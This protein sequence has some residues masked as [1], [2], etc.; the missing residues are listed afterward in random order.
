M[1]CL[2]FKSL[3][4]LTVYKKC[5]THARTRYIDITHV[6]QHHGSELCSS[7][8]GLHALTGC[9][10]VSAFSGFPHLVFDFQFSVFGFSVFQLSVFQ[11][12][13]F[14]FS[15]FSFPLYGFPVWGFCFTVFRIRVFVFPVF[16]IRVFVFQFSVFG[17]SFSVFHIWVFVFQF[18]VFGFL[19]FSFLYLGF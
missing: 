17:F 19:I 18:S 1:L 12:S 15:I 16:R 3:L 13:V 5:G 4:P 9:D 6:V 8:R 10:S 2:A 14:G 7:L 11:F